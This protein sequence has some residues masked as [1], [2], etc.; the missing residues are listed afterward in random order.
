M[1][2]TM[3]LHVCHPFDI[4]NLTDIQIKFEADEQSTLG[5][6]IV[7]IESDREIPLPVFDRLV[8]GGIDVDLLYVSYGDFDFFDEHGD[9]DDYE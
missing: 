8:D 1:V 6:A 4:Y 9:L 7:A 3:Q 2:T 5:R